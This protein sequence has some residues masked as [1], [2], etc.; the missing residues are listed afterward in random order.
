MIILER[1][2]SFCCAAF[3]EPRSA[4]IGCRTCKMGWAGCTL[5]IV[6]AFACLPG[7]C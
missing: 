6:S 3:M 2:A 5:E 4:V 7:Q 1:E